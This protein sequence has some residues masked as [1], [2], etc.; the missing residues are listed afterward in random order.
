MRD[1]PIMRRGPPVHVLVSAG[2]VLRAQQVS[3]M[4][5]AFQNID[6]EDHGRGAAHDGQE[7]GCERGQRGVQRVGG[8]E[9]EF[10][11]VV[12]LGGEGHCL[13]RE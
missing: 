2:M 7:A 1:Y 3:N 9:V 8:E 12:R 5:F 13:R 4:G 10:G 11:E 6:L